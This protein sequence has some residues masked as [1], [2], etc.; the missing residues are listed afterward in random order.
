MIGG[1]K[2]GEVQNNSYA[3]L[4]YTVLQVRNKIHT[5]DGLQLVTLSHQ[6]LSTAQIPLPATHTPP[7]W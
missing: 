7:S 2:Q 5:G 4:Y 1:K 3:I 6:P